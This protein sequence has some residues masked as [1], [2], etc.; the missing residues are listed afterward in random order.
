VTRILYVDVIGGAAGDMLLAALLDAGAASTAVQQAVDAVL[1]DRF[2]IATEEVHR[3]HLRARLLRA[4]PGS[5]PPRTTP[6]SFPE[7]LT[8]VDSAPLSPALRGT[9][10]SIL[11][12]L[13]DAEAQVHGEPASQVASQELG[14]DDTL[15][16]VVGVAAALESLQVSR[17]FVSPIPLAMGEALAGPHGRLPLPAPATLELLRGFLVRGDGSGE[18]VTPTAA[19]I[20]AAVAVPA[21][22]LP[23]MTL[24]CIGYGAG[25]RDPEGLPNVV[26]VLAGPALAGP[27][28]DRPQERELVVLEANIDDLSP[29]LVADAAETLRG[30]GALDV[31]T[32]PAQMKKGRAAVILSALCDPALEPALSSVFFEAT[33]TFGVRIHQVRRVELER[34][35]VDVALPEGKVRVKLGVLGGRL[36]SATPEH[37]DVAEVARQSRQPVRLVYEKA[38]AAAR[39]R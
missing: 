21:P 4:R 37:D 9:A 24:E 28:A 25:Q 20:F 10:Q 36:M 7:L 5:R 15:L 14:D 1:P 29:E 6:W 22:D 23:R 27:A 13:A 30:A 12:R 17:V 2:R 18:V 39:N 3:A 19:A 35:W 11:Q 16:D 32:A 26:R 38:L 34:R 33:S 31:W 8:A